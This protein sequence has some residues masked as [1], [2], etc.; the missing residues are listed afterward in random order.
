MFIRRIVTAALT[1]AALVALSACVAPNG[2]VITPAPGGGVVVTPPGGIGGTVDTRLA[3][4]WCFVN[5]RG[6]EAQR[7]IRVVR[8]GLLVSTPRGQREYIRVASGR[9]E[10]VN[11]PSVYQFNSL[12]SGVFS[13]DGTNRTAFNLYRCGSSAGGSGTVGTV[14]SRLAGN[15]CFINNRGREARRTITAR[16]SS[17]ILTNQYGNIEYRPVGSG[18]YE[19][20][21]G[22]GILL[23]NSLNDGTLSRDGTRR[24]A[25]D[26]YRC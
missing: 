1:G 6:R 11:G 3:G 18:R 24:T 8:N 20:A 16:R 12:S 14:D 2:T 4:N 22:A 9:F 26:L 25:V 19:Q 5:N 15:W 21:G 13:R 7:D 10:E 17:L 23:F